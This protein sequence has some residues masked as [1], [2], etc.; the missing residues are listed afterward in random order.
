[1]GVKGEIRLPRGLSHDDVVAVISVQ[2][3]GADK[4]ID[5][6]ITS[7]MYM[8]ASPYNIFLSSLRAP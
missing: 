7:S 1:M 2:V 6:D 4:P 5:H 3:K 8:I